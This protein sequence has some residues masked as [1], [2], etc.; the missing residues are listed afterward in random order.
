MQ[1]ARRIQDFAGALPPPP[2]PPTP[3]SNDNAEERGLTGDDPRSNDEFPTPMWVSSPKFQILRHN[4]EKQRRQHDS[5]WF[6]VGY[7][8]DPA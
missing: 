7:H 8:C 5:S 1:A 4:P 2:V 6:S 3:P